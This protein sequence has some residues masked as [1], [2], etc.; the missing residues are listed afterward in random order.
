MA[1]GERICVGCGK[2]LTGRQM[3]YC[4]PACQVRVQRGATVQLRSYRGLFQLTKAELERAG[5]LNTVPGQQ[6]LMLAQQLGAKVINVS[7]ISGLSREFSRV[8]ADAMAGVTNQ[9]DVVD[10]LR[11]RR[12]RKRHVA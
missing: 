1:G 6:A 4:S 12:D 2:P 3:K 9:S 11:K 7:G 10:E 8:Y 5:R